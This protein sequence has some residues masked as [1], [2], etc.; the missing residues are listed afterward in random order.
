MGIVSLAEIAAQGLLF[1]EL[2]KVKLYV[3]NNHQ[4]NFLDCV[5]SRQPT[6]TPVET[7]HHSTIPGHLGLISMLVG[8][9]LRW[10]VKHEK[11]IDDSAASE[12]LSRPYR[13]PWHL[14]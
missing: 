10:D 2:A 8:R 14:A 5:K 6:I 9:K 3:S 11:I 1:S 12:L 13:R 7:G 4:R